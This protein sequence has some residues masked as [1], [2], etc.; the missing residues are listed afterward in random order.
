MLYGQFKIVGSLGPH[1]GNII[2][3]RVNENLIAY[4]DP[5][6]LRHTHLFVMGL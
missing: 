2:F 6:F 3:L 4:H 1:N 5:S